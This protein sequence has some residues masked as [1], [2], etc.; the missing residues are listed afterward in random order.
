[1]Y[2]RLA[3]LNQIMVGRG[4]GKASDV[5]VGF[6]E[7]LPACSAGA[8][9]V[10]GAAVGAGAGRSH[11]LGGGGNRWL[12]KGNTQNGVSP[13][14]NDMSVRSANILVFPVAKQK[15]ERDR[16]REIDYSE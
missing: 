7:L 5:Q 12:P 14:Q 6:T 13:R 8:T 9:A 16:H 4:W 15:R 10:V 2:S 11:G 1:M 3:E